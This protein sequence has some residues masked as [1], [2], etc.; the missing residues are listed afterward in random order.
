[1]TKTPQ[2]V[3]LT[4]PIAA[5]KNAVAEELSRRLSGGG[6]TVVVADV[7]DVAAMVGPPGAGAVGLWFTAHQAHGALIGQW[8]RSPV[9]YVVAVGPIYTVAEQEALTRTLPDGSMPLWVVIDAPVDV[10]LSRAQS[11]L[12]RG[13][14]RDSEFH[15]A[16]HRRFREL[17]GGIPASATFNSTALSA[18]LIATAIG[19]LL[20]GR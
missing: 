11:D 14:S 6:H 9:E 17:V 7:D 16:A 15:R 20:A 12:A 8:M 3:V 2:L 4:G 5:G 10:T 1:M 18:A 19:D 13:Q